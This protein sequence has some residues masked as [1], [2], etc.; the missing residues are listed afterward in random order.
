[1][2]GG[3]RGVNGVIVGD[4][5]VWGLVCLASRRGTWGWLPE[6]KTS[7]VLLDRVGC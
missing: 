4:G 7:L 2:K 6:K 1:M 5:K 3:W